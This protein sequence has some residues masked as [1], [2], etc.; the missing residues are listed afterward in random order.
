[1]SA[2]R[3]RSAMKRRRDTLQADAVQELLEKYLPQLGSKS[4]VHGIR[5]TGL[6]IR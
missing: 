6:F 4:F 1:M 5:I 2:H 3:E